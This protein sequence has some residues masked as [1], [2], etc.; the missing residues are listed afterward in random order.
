VAGYGS[1]FTF[2]NDYINNSTLGYGVGV[3][4]ANKIN[5]HI[6]IRL[7]VYTGKLLPIAVDEEMLRFSL[8]E[9]YIFKH[10][11]I[12]LTLIYRFNS[13]KMLR[14]YVA[15]GG[16]ANYL[17]EVAAQSSFVSEISTTVEE[18]KGFNQFNLFLGVG[19]YVWFGDHIGMIIQA[20][21]DMNPFVEGAYNYNFAFTGKAGLTYHF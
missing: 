8:Y 15:L 18:D 11:N 19:S 16:E 6:G 17:R 20:T 14:P 21:V 7:G 2:K 13:E 1:Q 4:G 5:D 12:P 10:L 9:N 3:F